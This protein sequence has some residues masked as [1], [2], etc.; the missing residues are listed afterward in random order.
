MTPKAKKDLEEIERM[1]KDLGGVGD[2]VKNFTN[3]TKRM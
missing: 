1:V 3:A 2:Q